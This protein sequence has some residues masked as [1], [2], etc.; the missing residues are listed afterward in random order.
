MTIAQ[1]QPQ[2]SGDSAAAPTAPAGGLPLSHRLSIVYLAAPVVVWLV[3]WFE[4]WIGLPV[5]GLLVAGLWGGRALSGSWRISLSLPVLVSLLAALAWTLLTPVGGMWANFVN[6]DLEGNFYILLEIGRGEWPTYVTDY[7]NDESPLLSYYLGFTMIP[8]LVGRWLGSSTLSWVLPLYTWIG[9]GLLIIVFTRGLSTLRALLISIVVL[10]FFSGMEV[11]QFVLHLGLLDAWEFIFS[12]LRRN[13]L[14]HQ[15]LPTTSRIY[16]TFISNTKNLWDTPQH[17]IASG[18]VTV[19][20]IQSRH[21]LRFAAVSGLVIAICLFWSPMSAIGLLP[22][23]A[24]LVYINGVKPFLKWPNLLATPPLIGLIALFLTNNDLPSHFGW[25]WQSYANLTEMFIDLIYGYLT[26]FIL[27]VI[28]LILMDRQIIKN[29]IFITS[30]ATLLAAPLLVYNPEISFYGYGSV[31]NIYY[32]MWIGSVPA[33]VA[34][35]YF[36]A[37]TLIAHLPEIARRNDTAFSPAPLPYLRWL[38]IPLIAILAVGA[39]TPLSVFLSNTNHSHSVYD[40]T[41]STLLTHI[42]HT[43]I[44]PRIMTSIPGLLQTFLRESGQKGLS[45]GDPIIRSKYDIYL[46]PRENNLVYLNRGCIPEL[47]KNTRFFLHIFPTNNNDLPTVT[48]KV[49]YEIKENRWNFYTQGAND[50]IAIFGLP[51]YDIASIVTGQY[52]HY[53]GT[54]WSVEYRFNDSDKTVADHINRFDPTDTYQ[55]Y[56]SYYQLAIANEPIIR[57]TFNIHQIKLHQ[58]TLIY[59]KEHCTSQDSQT[60]FFLHITPSDTEDLPA[61]RRESGFDNYDF[62]FNQKGT[63]FDNKCLAVIP[64]PDYDNAAITTGQFNPTD[65][66]RLWQEEAILYR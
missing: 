36:T 55:A 32:I 63:R 17:F 51:G 60:P 34:L 26:E 53:L 44:S 31:T 23:A 10:V 18:L 39:L 9:L 20:I 15:F 47:E 38:T 61:H 21:Q 30:I 42:S 57:S 50:C 8:G 45:I 5:A 48:Q 65:G 46:Q 28:V 62:V 16:P 12:R 2:T 27:L 54:E 49:G 35:T 13:L 14:L 56:Y 58:N 22:L 7:L 29:P 64:I 4:W 24:A 59:T 40:R 41:E 1:P 25:L 37:R 19:I 52:S 11:L 66:H 3:G 33:L 43:H 6:E